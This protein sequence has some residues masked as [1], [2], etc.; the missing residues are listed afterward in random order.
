[1]L[2]GSRYP[3]CVSSPCFASAGETTSK[4]DNPTVPFLSFVP[5]L[6][7]PRNNMVRLLTFD[8]FTGV[9]ADAGREVAGV[10]GR[11]LSHPSAVEFVKRTVSGNGE[12]NGEHV[13]MPE[14]GIFLLSGSLYASIVA[15]SLVSTFNLAS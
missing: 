15:V 2:L 12:T 10:V 5:F 1:M 13:E 8:P 9:Y 11:A 6:F 3:S 14:W 7:T 4:D